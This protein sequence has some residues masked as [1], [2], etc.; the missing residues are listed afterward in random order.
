MGNSNIKDFISGFEDYSDS[1]VAGVLLPEINIA[2]R[3]Y[4][5]LGITEESSN[6]EFL[7]QLCRD[8]I[9]KHKINVADNKDKYYERVKMELSILDELG[10]VDYILLNWD[11]LNF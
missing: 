7:T 5:K 6:L 2:S 11:I 3:F 10:F 9:K 4:K 1:V 8:G